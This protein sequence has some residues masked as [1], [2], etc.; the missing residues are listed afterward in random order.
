MPTPAAADPA[1]LPPRPGQHRLAVLGFPA[2]HSLSPV[3]HRRAFELC[4]LDDWRYDI[5][6]LRPTEVAEFIASR[7]ASWRGFSVTMPLKEVVAGLGAPDPLVGRIGV[8]NTLVVDLGPGG[9]S[10][11]TY[12]T[13]VGGFVAAVTGTGLPAPASAVVVG[14]GATALSALVALGSLGARVTVAAR[15]SAKA[16][17]L[18]ARGADLGVATATTP[19]G[20][21]PA[22]DA[23]VSTV[24]EAALAPHVPAILAGRPALVFDVVY[25]PWP[26]RLATS[27]AAAG[28]AVLSG[29][30]LLVHQA[31]AQFRLFTGRD[32]PAEPL[33]LAVRAEAAR[34]AMT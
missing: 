32:V 33:L 1:L 5:V 27:A 21:F 29:L 6:E 7:D 24:P 26:T 25:H 20:E 2:S 14:S 10:Y 8:A 11:R 18:A 22:C 13:D 30:D 17:A 15:N 12:N 23:V 16:E 19:W 3:I 9:R 4:G 31:V 34:R 28:V